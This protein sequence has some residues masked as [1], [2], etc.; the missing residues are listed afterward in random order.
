MRFSMF[1]ALRGKAS[2][3]GSL[4][5][6]GWDG[7]PVMLLAATVAALVVGACVFVGVAGATV[8]SCGPAVF[9]VCD[10]ESPITASESGP[11]AT[12]AGS[13]PYALTTTI[14]FNNEITSEEPVEEEN[15]KEEMVPIGIGLPT[16][17]IY[18]SPKHIE[19]NL[20]AGVVVNPAA[21]PRKCTELQFETKEGSGQVGGCPL[22]SVVGIVTVY[23]MGADAAVSSPVYN[24]VPPPGVPAE[25]GVSPGSI[26]LIAHIMGKV[27]TGGDYG[28]S[29]S[30][31]GITQFQPIYSVKLT[32]WGDP[33]NPSHDRERGGCANTFSVQKEIEEE[34]F[35]KSNEEAVIEHTQFRKES[36]YKFRCPVG[37]NER[38]YIPL[39]TMPGSCT[40]NPYESTLSVDS[41]QEPGNEIMPAPFMSPAVTGCDELPFHPS[42]NAEPSSNAGTE[43]PSGLNVDLRIPQ[44][45][46]IEGRAEADL[47][48]TVVSLPAGIAISPSAAN[49]LG[50]CP[51][52]GPGGFNLHEEETETNGEKHSPRGHCPDSSKIGTVEV[53]TPLLEKPLAGSV[54]IAQPKC[55]GTG[56]PGCTEESASNGELFGLYL[57]V[58]G[59]GAI[60]KLAGTVSANP[61][62]G[63][64]TTTF[65]NNP[66][67]P[68]DELKLKLFSGPRAPLITPSDCGTYTTT[69]LLSPWSGTS[70]VPWPSDFTINQGCTHAFNPTFTAGT[71][72][73]QAG[74][75]S[76][77]SVTLSRQDGEQR[78]GGVQVIAP[79]G[80]LASIKNV[81]QCPEPQ[82][83]QGTCGPGSE[84]G[85]T[86]VA[87]GPGTDPY[88]VK[89]GKVY[90]TGPY[91]G[92]PFGLSIV[93]PAVAGPFN[94][95]QE[96]VRARIDVDSHT[97]QAT[98]TSDPLP[99]IKDGIPLDVRTVNVTI[100]RS[101]FMFNPT[102]CSPLSVGGT[103]ESTSTTKTAVSNPFEAANCASLPFK[104]SFKVSTQASTSKANGASL[105][106]KVGSSAGQANI[107]KV[108]VTLP[109]QLPARLTTLQKACTEA[110]F[111]INPA[112]CPVQS[113]VG[114]ATAVTPLL[115]HPL[116]GPAY[117]V[118]HGGAAFPDLVF[119]LQGEG[120]LLYLDG[121]TNIKKG[122]TTSTF[123]SVPDAPIS[124][125][126]TVFPE[127]S[128][129]V[130]ATNIPA[131]AKNNMCGQKLTM[132]T[133][134]TG[135]N[136]AVTT[137]TTKIAVTGCPK[138]KKKAK[139][140]HKGH[141]GKGK[142]KK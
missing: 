11:P 81:V 107:A 9:G 26:G 50:A 102:N 96:I 79:P 56:Q 106:V 104:P 38:T 27:R 111:N 34:H 94:L 37:E 115:A 74:A 20:P 123:N 84:I 135:Q 28:L 120:I 75:Y 112:G 46:S 57:E 125:F 54:F 19:V 78:L 141:G 105:T 73:N 72:N 89:G 90:L 110:Q 88:W 134:I 116:T 83:S 2:V 142:G 13:H 122:I 119:V 61:S 55:G 24:M 30:V 62:T 63:Q 91:K 82:A 65:D 127:G 12:L 51:A 133:T 49:G 130:L 124:T 14:V 16:G 3:R 76:P 32:L 39:L 40:G 60:V 132:P 131:K 77:F 114:N 7:R 128:H 58:E 5:V 117:L 108:R 109:K 67:L 44:D 53:L 80:L 41:W 100:D 71:T 29:G 8:G 97:A 33:T 17:K 4:P 25:F 138:V 18:G 140:K 48:K 42:L 126:E 86:T 1:D 22:G 103:L 99:T 92:S 59:Q 95:G 35:K 121:N 23:L 137:Q 139:A 31:S 85:E 64:L 36:E 118:S 98:V 113:D 21:S 69:S 45:E 66:Q 101:G 6:V 43:S 15:A 87:V 136:G 70:T 93:V 47:K 68:F 129:S 52:E 10:F